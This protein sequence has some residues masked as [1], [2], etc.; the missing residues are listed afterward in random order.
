MVTTQPRTNVSRLNLSA[1]GEAGG[2]EVQAVGGV[3]GRTGAVGRVD[4]LDT[5][6]PA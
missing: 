3:V 1:L 6:T 2:G 4:W 5:A